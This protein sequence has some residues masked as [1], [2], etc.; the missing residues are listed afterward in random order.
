MSVTEALQ[1]VVRGESLTTDAAIAAMTTIMEGEATPAQV[2]AL[3]T[4][5]RMKGETVEEIAGFARVMREKS[6]RLLPTR[7]PLVDTCGTGGDKLKTF[8]ISTAAA[9]VVAGAGVGVAKH[10]NRSVTSKSGSADVL[11][12]LGVTLAIPPAAVEACIDRIGVGFLFAPNFHPAMKFAAPVRREIGIRT[13]FNIL[14]P[15]T[16]PAGAPH[17]VIGV[18]DAA[19]T[20]PLARVLGLLGARRAFV[21]HGL[22]GLDE[23]STAGATQVS[24]LRD[25]QVITRVYTPAEF[26]LEEANPDDLLGGNPAENAELIWALFRGQDGPK[27]DIVLLNAAAAL[28]AGGAAMAKLQALREMT[29]ELAPA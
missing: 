17:Q 6:V 24:E 10:G 11:E 23:W 13:V 1:Q 27:R 26:G 5:L 25:G 29:R 9:F 28:V 2:A 18:Y 20:E 8:N 16:N 15:L 7:T 4:A 12:E 14:G 19:L 3:L 22:I 21:V